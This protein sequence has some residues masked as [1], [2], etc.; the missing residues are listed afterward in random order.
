VSRI[1]RV[2]HG[3]QDI[4]GS[5][6]QGNNPS[7]LL[8]EVRPAFDMFPMWASERVESTQVQDTPTGI[9]FK[10]DI[11]IPEAEAWIPF[12]TSMRLTAVTAADAF[13]LEVGIR[14][15]G[16]QITSVV[17]TQGFPRVV[18]Q[19][20]GDQIVRGYVF[21]FP[22]M[23][24]SGSLF[25]WGFTHYTTVGADPTVTASVMYWRLNV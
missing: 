8:Q 9:G 15:G 20:A 21:R 22:Q 24:L 11:E 25:R 5:Q 19:T 18:I 17:P 16:T 13:G 4:L 1:N 10:F 7:I 6:A 14:A 12:Y 2:P 23:Y 3:L